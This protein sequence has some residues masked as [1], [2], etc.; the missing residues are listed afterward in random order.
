MVARSSLRLF[1]AS[2]L[3]AC[4]M[5]RLAGADQ[6]D[7]FDPFDSVL[8]TPGVTEES[9]E[10]KS[11][12]EL[13]AEGT[14]LMSDERYLD[15]RTKLLKALQRDPTQYRAH[16]LLASY[17]SS[18]VGHFRLALKYM[19]RAEQLFQERWGAPPYSSAEQRIEHGHLLYLLANNRLDLDNYE[20]ALEVLDQFSAA[21]YYGEWY[22]GTRAW[23]LMKSGRVEDA[24]KVARAGVM[25]GAEPGRTLNML[26]ILLSM[27]GQRS[28]ALQVFRQAIAYEMSLGDAGQPATPLNNAGEV[29]KE[30]FSENE[31]EVSWLRSTS[32]RDGCEHVLPSLN[33]A[34][35]Y[36][37]QLRY[38]DAKKAIDDF[39]RCFAQFPLRNDEEHR[40]LVQLARGRLLLLSG[41]V[42]GALAL[43]EKAAEARQWL[44][45]IGTNIEDLR[46]GVMMSL[47]Q[48][49]AAK[50]ERLR[51]QATSSLAEY[52]GTVRARLAYRARGWWLMRRTRQVLAEDLKGVE[53][54]YVRNTDSLVEYPTFGEVLAGFPAG[55][56]RRRLALEQQSD[57]RDGARPYYQAYLAEN[58]IARGDYEEARDLLQRAQQALRVPYD[59]AL[60]VKIW[61]LQLGMLDPASSAYRTLAYQIYDRVPAQLANY[62]FSLPVAVDVGS[63]GT[64]IESYIEGSA[65]RVAESAPG[66]MVYELD[67]AEHRFVFKHGAVQREGKGSSPEAALNTLTKAVFA[68]PL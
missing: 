48:A 67:G 29:Y 11:A 55:L 24:T 45:K 19:K 57:E 44:G 9:D 58:L 23:V 4:S 33:L 31:A 17:Y 13:I 22:P 26:G 37:D 36:I 50:R 40:A 38:R 51:I 64:E 62:G 18:V 54:L 61:L 8:Q 65:F 59:D 43:L 6:T 66:R 41:D 1:V 30:T 56:L 34:L 35:L 68:A 3:C 15:A 53:D 49:V 25:A 7:P 47:A 63:G 39:Q 10:G 60:A 14:A 32:M 12:A 46:A 5:A 20:G 2:V 21:G 27:Q 52:L 42:D 28:Q 16:I